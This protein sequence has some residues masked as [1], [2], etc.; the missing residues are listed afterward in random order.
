MVLSSLYSDVDNVA[1]NR[2]KGISVGKN[3]VSGL[4]SFLMVFNLLSPEV[5]YP[6]PASAKRNQQPSQPQFSL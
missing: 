2:E 1:Q 6:Q 5:L 4:F 3:D